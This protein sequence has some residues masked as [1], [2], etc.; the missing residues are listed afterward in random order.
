MVGADNIMGGRCWLT[1]G[2]LFVVVCMLSQLRQFGS[3]VL[4]NSGGT[5][6][7]NSGCG[8]GGQ[9]PVRHLSSSAHH[10]GGGGGWA[11]AISKA[12][13]AIA[14]KQDSQNMTDEILN[15]PN[16]YERHPIV[17]T[18]GDQILVGHYVFPTETILEMASSNY[19]NNQKIAQQKLLP[20]S[21]HQKELLHDS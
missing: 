13:L 3:L 16:Y 21:D 11:S 15:N 19:L 20:L 14:E 10:R 7:D 4:D 8:G 12:T 9:Q 5:D 18:T 6:D 2:T 17:G 1:L